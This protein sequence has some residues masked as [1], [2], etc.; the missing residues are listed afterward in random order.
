MT[1]GAGRDI[2]RSRIDVYNDG[3]LSSNLY[4]YDEKIKVGRANNG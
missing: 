1:G 3:I 4:D 2:V